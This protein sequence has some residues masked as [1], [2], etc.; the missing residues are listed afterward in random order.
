M[1]CDAR[2][3]GQPRVDVGV[4]VRVVVVADDVQA[5]TR[6]GPG[7]DLEEAEELGLAVPLIAAVGDRAGGDL[8]GGE[9][10]RGAVALV[11]VGSFLG[12]TRAHRQDRLGAVEG[13]N[14]ALFIDTEHDRIG[15]LSR[16]GARCRDYSRSVSPGRSPNPACASPRTGLSTVAAVRQWQQRSRGWGW[17][18]PGSDTGL[19][20]PMPG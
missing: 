5:A 12:Q 19:P 2:V 18:C 7:H 4:F 6:V 10:G 16:P 20:V 8:Q 3:F 15:W 11:V 17:W 14:L 13:L 1:Q 9:Q